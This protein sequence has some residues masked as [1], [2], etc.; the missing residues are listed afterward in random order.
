MRPGIWL[1]S[2][3]G[4][5]VASDEPNPEDVRLRRGP[6]PD[7]PEPGPDPFPDMLEWDRRPTLVPPVE[8]RY[9]DGLAVGTPEAADGGAKPAA[10]VKPSPSRLPKA[11]AGWPGGVPRSAEDP[12]LHLAKKMRPPPGTDRVKYVGLLNQGLTKEEALWL[13]V[14]SA[15]PWV[16]RRTIAELAAKDPPEG[17]PVDVAMLKAIEPKLP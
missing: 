12:R 13:L 9:Q 16:E 14:F 8:V 4:L 1:L 15:K 11:D 10:P 17:D 5:M 6:P 2:L 3:L 7:P